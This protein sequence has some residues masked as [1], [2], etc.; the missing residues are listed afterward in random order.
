MELSLLYDAYNPK[1][2]PP[3]HILTSSNT[4]LNL[5]VFQHSFTEMPHGSLWCVFSLTSTSC[6]KPK[7]L[8]FRCISDGL[9]LEDVD[10]A[11]QINYVILKM[12]M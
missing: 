5:C 7:L 2:T 11:E 3:P 8:N 9:E 6:N 1:K 12:R 4:S 10:K